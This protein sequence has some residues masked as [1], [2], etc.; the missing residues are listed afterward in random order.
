[1]RF[2]RADEMLRT[3]EGMGRWL[4]WFA[5]AASVASLA[6]C[7]GCETTQGEC[8]QTPCSALEQCVQGQCVF[9][10]DLVCLPSCGAGEVCSNGACIPGV[11]TCSMAG[12]TCDAYK[13]ISGDFY[14][15]DWDGLAVGQP[16]QCSN[17][18]QPDGSCP[19]GEACYILTGL[20]DTACAAQSDCGVGRICLNSLCR[21]AACQ[22]S[23]CVGRYAGIEDCAE[24]KGSDPAYPY[25][26]ACVPQL[27]GTSQ[28]VPAGLAGPG[29]FCIS[30]EQAE[31]LGNYE[32]TCRQGSSCVQGACRRMCD[33]GEGQ[34]LEGLDCLFEEDSFL[35]EGVGFCGVACEPFSVGQCGQSQ[36]CLPVA[37]GKGYCVPA[38]PSKAYETCLPNSFNC[39][40]GTTC[41]T[42]QSGQSR[43]LPMCDV[44]VAPPEGST[45][46]TAS[47]QAARDATCPVPQVPTKSLLSV[48]HMGQRAGSVDVYVDGQGPALAMSLNDGQREG[49]DFLEVTPGAHVISILSAGSSPIEPPLAELQVALWKDEAYL[50]VLGAAAPNSSTV[51][52]PFLVTLDREADGP[53]IRVVQAMGD[54]GSPVDVIARRGAGDVVLLASALSAQRAVAAPVPLSAGDYRV[55]VWPQG[56]VDAPDLA[57]L[58]VAPSVRLGESLQEELYLRGTLD[59]D[60]AV[61]AGVAVLASSAIPEVELGPAPLTCQDLN[62]GA[63]GY[64]EQICE[65]TRAYQE[66]VCDGDGMSC[67]PVQRASFLGRISLCRPSGSAMLGEPCDPALETG[68]CGPDLYC[69]EF[70]NTASDFSPS[71][72]RGR[73]QPLCDV[74]DAEHPTLRCGPE[75][76]CQSLDAQFEVGRCGYACDASS[77]YSDAACPAGLGS[78]KPLASATTQ[79]GAS[80]EAIPSVEA[81]APFCSASGS[82]APGSPCGGSDCVPG[83]EC[84]YPRSA[85]RDL[86]STLLSPYFGATGLVPTCQP[87]C[88]P[89]DGD[90]SQVRC[91]AEETC[92]VNYPWSAEVGHCAPI[93]ERVAPFTSC[94]RPGESCGEDSVC[95]L[96]GGAPFC[97]RLCQ[98]VGGPA[99]GLYSQSSCE[100]GYSCAPLIDDVGFCQAN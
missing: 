27:D 96:D 85:Q 90:S 65:G 77:T 98:Y 70:G 48:V 12:Q 71:Q 17:P 22:R 32:L 15:V 87:I 97:L 14:C 43:C 75:Q 18:C 67:A 34:C 36:K 64:C 4:S 16:A 38:G 6:G 46:L 9:I 88:D 76:S 8:P 42:Y 41:V 23:E 57:P 37:A 100:V 25:G 86:V 55:E 28:C 95:V 7:S 2:K 45:S 56:L 5:F 78:C 73:C 89:F 54:V 74:N 44:T 30:D 79:T 61:D 35:D 3:F 24:K 72:P 50:V 33:G 83:S 63:Y 39:E 91:G 82:L 13:P 81:L 29:E 94:T 93:V 21:A 60:D 1:M 10:G 19:T 51:I 99:E 26:F 52:K 40:E 20:N 68:A 66:Q 59:P 47:D 84:M 31:Q 58:L 69:L 11:E 49:A 62:N 92:L 80:G 53:G